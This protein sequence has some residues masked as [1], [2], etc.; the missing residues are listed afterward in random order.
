M[1]D[2]GGLAANEARYE[3]ALRR[4]AEEHI[5]M[6]LESY[7]VLW[8]CDAAR[9]DDPAGWLGITPAAW[10]ALK[11]QYADCIAAARDD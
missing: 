9:R 2:P 8:V 1:T 10:A 11:D 3:A 5:R 4:C 7:R 6:A